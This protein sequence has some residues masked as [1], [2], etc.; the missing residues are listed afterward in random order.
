MIE[1]I[2][3]F[4]ASFNSESRIWRNIGYVGLTRNSALN[5]DNKIGLLLRH[6]HNWVDVD[7]E[8]EVNLRMRLT[9]G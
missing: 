3:N 1:Q 7:I 9:W 6:S 5:L 4:Y 8:A 2:F